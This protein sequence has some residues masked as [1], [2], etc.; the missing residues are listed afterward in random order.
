MHYRASQFDL[1]GKVYVA[2]AS[3]L[4]TARIMGMLPSGCQGIM[5]GEPGSWCGEFVFIHYDYDAS[6]EDIAGWNFLPS[7]ETVQKMPTMAGR[8]VL[9]IN[10]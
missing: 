10:D 8:K 1:N 7:M 5:L 9:I 6:G 4:N 3:E 2:E